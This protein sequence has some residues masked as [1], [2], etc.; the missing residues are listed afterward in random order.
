MLTSFFK[1]NEGGGIV[2]LALISAVASSFLYAS[3]FNIDEKAFN[4]MLKEKEREMST[5]EA[6]NP[7]K[8]PSIIR[9]ELN[10]ML[11]SISDTSD[12]TLD[13][14]VALKIDPIDLEPLSSTGK[15]V[16]EDGKAKKSHHRW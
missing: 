1:L 15:A 4:K 8:K 14:V 16:V 9:G 10:E 11:K 12:K 6:K 13:V 3:D 5:L 7:V 2:S